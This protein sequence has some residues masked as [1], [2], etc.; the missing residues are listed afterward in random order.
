MEISFIC[1]LL[2]NSRLFKQIVRDLC[3]HNFTF[4]SE[5]DFNEFTKSWWIVVFKS[6]SITKCFKNRISFKN[7]FFNSFD[8]TTRPSLSVLRY[9]QEIEIRTFKIGSCLREITEDNLSGLGLTGTGFTRDDNS[10][11]FLLNHHLLEGV[12]CDHEYV[13]IHFVAGFHAFGN[14]QTFNSIFSRNLSIK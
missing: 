11:I 8:R 5:V 10:L 13:G 12:F 3:K 1:Q 6:F 14:I 7:L 2:D 9:I 4:I